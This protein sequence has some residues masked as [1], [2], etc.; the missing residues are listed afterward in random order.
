MAAVWEPGKVYNY[1][2]NLQPSR[3]AI[4]VVVT[5]WDEQTLVVDDIIF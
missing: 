4:N 1:Y 2:I 3:V 5:D